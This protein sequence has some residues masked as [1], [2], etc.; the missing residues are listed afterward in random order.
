VT[1]SNI[2]F[3]KGFTIIKQ[4]TRRLLG[5][6]F[7]P[8]AC[9]FLLDPARKEKTSHSKRITIKKENKEGRDKHGIGY[10]E[11]NFLILSRILL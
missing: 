3:S 7:S 10:F 2:G 8:Q 6:I 4:I 9:T 1:Y 11:I 5:N